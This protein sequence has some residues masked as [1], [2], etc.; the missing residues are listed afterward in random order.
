MSSSG[1]VLASDATLQTRIRSGR[2]PP[3]KRERY[4]FPENFQAQ[5]AQTSREGRGLRPPAQ[6]VPPYELA[7]FRLLAP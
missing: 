4:G 7:E 1:L 6:G 3:P 2:A 5:S